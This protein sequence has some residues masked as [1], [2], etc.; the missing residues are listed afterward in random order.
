[1][2]PGIVT[3]VPTLRLS[4]IGVSAVPHPTAARSANS[5]TP[6]TGSWVVGRTVDARSGLAVGDAR[7]SLCYL[8]G[9]GGCLLS[10]AQTLA[11]GA[12]NLT[13]VHGSYQMWVNG[14]HY[15]GSRVYLNASTAGTV[16]LGAILLT[17]LDRI[18]GRV[19]IEPWASLGSQ[20]GEGADQVRIS[21]CDPRLV[22]G[23]TQATNTGGF[24]NVSV[25]AGNPDTV[26]LTGGG[27]LGAGNGFPGFSPSSFTLTVSSNQVTVPGGGPGGAVLFLILGGLSGSLRETSGG[28]TAPAYFATYGTIASASAGPSI[29]AMTGTAGNYTAFLPDGAYGEQVDAN[30]QGLV[31]A[32]SSGVAGTT[33]AGSVVPGPNLTLTRFGFVDAT[34]LDTTTLYPA[35]GVGVVVTGSGGPSNQLLTGGSDS[36]GTGSVNISAAPGS[37]AIMS[38][39]TAFANWSSTV[40]VSAGSATAFGQIRLTEIP[41]GGV[42]I[43]RTVAVNTVSTPPTVGVD[44]NVTFHPVE[45][46]FV[47]EDSGTGGVHSGPANGNDLGQF[48]LSGLPSNATNISVAATGFT[49]Y[50]TSVDLPAGSTYVQPLLNLTADGIVE[51]TVESMPGNVTVPYTTVVACPITK[52]L[53]PTAVQTNASGVFWVGVPAGLDQFTVQSNIYLANLTQIVNVTPDSFVE[54][55][56]IPVFGFATVHG[57][58]RGLPSGGLL[59]GA[60]VSLCSMFS[61]PNGC[62]PDETVTTDA[63]GTF[64]IP[65]PPGQY[66]LSASAPFYNTTRYFLSLN[67]GANLDLGIVFLAAYG[68]FTGTVVTTTGAP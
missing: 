15:V 5:S 22:C 53:C 29:S 63:N 57:I 14:S 25:P 9:A 37:D 16:D 39:S 61:P 41:G 2:T 33:T 50:Q 26:T 55:G 64:S 6:T 38:G 34:V 43:I 24:F 35:I 40:S 19:L 4:P 60:N 28:N 58:V 51:G 11:D 27:I 47:L 68:F 7:I 45:G 30:A 56:V 46:T 62:L 54:M 21:G 23:P 52:P 17:P 44:D 65:S 20:F 31:P 59:I 67:P 13:T 10:N 48:L 3:S 49:P 1:M 66:F 36:N 12:F 8:S 42:V 32:Q 18:T